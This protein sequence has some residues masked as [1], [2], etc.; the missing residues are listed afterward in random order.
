MY[1][2]RFAPTP[3]GP[4]HFGSLVAA[5]ASYL[6]ARTRGGEWLVR[7]EDIDPP[8]V[9]AGAADRI[10]FTLKQFGFTWDGPV[11]YQSTR[12][13]A[14]AA[15]LEQLRQ[16]GRAYPCSCTR[17][18][19]A[20]SASAALPSR[21]SLVYPGTCRQGV[22]PGRQ[23]RAW[24]FRVPATAIS[25]LDRLQGW[26]H[27]HLEQEAGDFVVFRADGLYAYQLAVVVDDAE[28]SI[29]DVV[30]GADLLASTPRQIALQHAL[31]YVTPTYLHVPV[32][33]GPDGLK[34]SKSAGAFDINDAIPAVLLWHA[35]QFLGQRL[36]E[37]LRQE[38]VT[39]LWQVAQQQW[40]EQAVPVSL[41]STYPHYL[42]NLAQH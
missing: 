27:I 24:R 6:A 28:Q 4:L 19:L 11:L 42:H 21:S 16:T 26:Q 9:M 33:T 1:R 23:A 40:E 38:S 37:E 29:T 10:L 41:S 17:K 12:L 32:V 20:D 7:I 30:R 14:Y 2:G 39:R 5:V 13:D 22:K 3:S 25:F 15:A 36:P 34:L 18:E 35:L 8:R 31:G